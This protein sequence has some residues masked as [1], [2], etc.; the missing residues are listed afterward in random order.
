MLN[1]VSHRSNSTFITC[2]DILRIRFDAKK[3]Q[4]GTTDTINFLIF[5]ISYLI[6]MCKIDILMIFTLFW[7]GRKWFNYEAMSKKLMFLCASKCLLQ[8]LLM[9]FY[10]QNKFEFWTFWTRWFHS[11]SVCSVPE[12]ISLGWT[13]SIKNKRLRRFLGL[14]RM[15][16]VV[17]YSRKNLFDQSEQMKL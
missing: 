3:L 9:S 13:A 5:N 12:I 16:Y 17:Y 6:E 14:L 10:S 8:K 4:L 15:S 11:G 7:Q 2:F 1:T